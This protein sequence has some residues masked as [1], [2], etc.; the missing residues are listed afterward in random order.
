MADYKGIKGFTIPTVSSDPSNPILGQIWYNS[1][2]D[3]LKGV[4][5][6]VGTWSSSNAMNTGRRF[7]AGLGTQATALAAGGSPVLVNLTE[8]YDGTSWTEDNDLNT[9]HGDGVSGF[10]TTSAGAAVGGKGSPASPTGI[11]SVEEWNGT[12]WT[13]ATAYPSS[14]AGGAS[15]GTQT[16]GIYIGGT[17]PAITNVTSEYDGTNWTSGGDLNTGRGYLAGFGTQVATVALAGYAP[18]NVSIQEQ[19]NGTSWTEAGDL[20]TARRSLGGSGSTTAGLGF[21]GYI[22]AAQDLTESYDGTSWTEVADL[23]TA[24]YRL[25]AGT[26]SPNTSSIGFGGGPGGKTDTEEWNKPDSTTVTVTTS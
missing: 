9:N 7:F 8:T 26:S 24:R 13:E 18:G 17:K 12:G 10:G 14:V 23:G 22:S 4:E 5:V 6:G 15:A 25:G 11:D 1:T 20:N 21:G 3:T 2:T 19:Y 16:S